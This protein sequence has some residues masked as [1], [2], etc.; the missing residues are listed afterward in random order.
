MRPAAK[1]GVPL[2][3]HTELNDGRITE[4]EVAYA[5]HA[6]DKTLAFDASLYAS[7]ERRSVGIV[8]AYEADENA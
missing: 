3:W 6:R 1:A 8:A 2:P 5:Q 4:L 7:V